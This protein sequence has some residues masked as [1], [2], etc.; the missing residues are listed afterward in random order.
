MRYYT[1]QGLLIQSS[2]V[3]IKRVKGWQPGTRGNMSIDSLLSF[4]CLI[5]SYYITGQFFLSSLSISLTLSFVRAV[6]AHNR[7]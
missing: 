2:V 4:V 1:E 6:S 5:A 3:E 7:Y